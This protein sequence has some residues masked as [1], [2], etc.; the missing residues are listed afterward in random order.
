MWRVWILGLLV[1]MQVLAVLPDLEFLVVT[2]NSSDAQ[3]E[4]DGYWTALAMPSERPT[5]DQLMREFLF[6]LNQ[7]EVFNAFNVLREHVEARTE[8]E[9]EYPDRLERLSEIRRL[10]ATQQVRLEIIR[11][12]LLIC[13]A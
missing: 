10:L 6:G 9:G 12:R 3:A 2:Q 11:R 13:R 8:L 1:S 5:V 4:Q 7:I